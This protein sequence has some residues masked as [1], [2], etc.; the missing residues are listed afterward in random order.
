[1]G[2]AELKSSLHQLIDGVTDTNLLEAVY[3][4]LSKAG[5]N[6]DTDWF[7]LLSDQQKSSIFRGLEDLKNGRIV[8]NDIA[9]TKISQKIARLK[10]G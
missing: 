5:S 8:S 4:L 10:N 2:S 3:A 6:V 1:M 9:L 7:D